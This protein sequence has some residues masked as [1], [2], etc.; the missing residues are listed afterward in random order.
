MKAEYISD[1]R[2]SL[3]PSAELKSR[4]MESAAKLEAGRKTFGDEKTAAD[5][6]QKTI[7]TK[8]K[9]E[10][11]TMSINNNEMRSVKSRLPAAVL[12]AAACAAIISPGNWMKT[13]S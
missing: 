8:E 12:S 3:E 1:I 9:K 7:K 4:V 2:R 6:S 5:K 13:A 10:K 11:I